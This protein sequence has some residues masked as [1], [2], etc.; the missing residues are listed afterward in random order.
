M[1]ADVTRKAK[2]QGG[3]L[4]TR[5]LLVVSSPMQAPVLLVNTRSMLLSCRSSQRV[6]LFVCPEYIRNC[7][8]TPLPMLSPCD[9][10]RMSQGV[11]IGRLLT[12]C[13]CTSHHIGDH[14]ILNACSCTGWVV[15]ICMTRIAIQLVRTHLQARTLNT[16]VLIY[17][18]DK[19]DTCAVLNQVFRCILLH[20]V[21]GSS[22]CF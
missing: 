10:T 3:S 12:G 14:N 20:T 21:L 8:G 18:A 17:T 16:R 7:V 4:A 6:Q 15:D 5:K 11:I 2:H 1:K 22:H 9:F 19:T 13:S